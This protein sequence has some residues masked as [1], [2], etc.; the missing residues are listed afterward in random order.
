MCSKLT[1]VIYSLDFSGQVTETLCASSSLPLKQ[2]SQ[3]CQLQKVI[4]TIKLG[5]AGKVYRRVC[6]CECSGNTVY[7]TTVTEHG[8]W[9]VAGGNTKQII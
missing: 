2:R 4:M 8:I 5:N 9:A 7:I 6:H 3:W 1:P